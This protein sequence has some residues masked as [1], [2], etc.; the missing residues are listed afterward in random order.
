MVLA[1]P[2]PQVPGALSSSSSSGSRRSPPG[3]HRAG[4][5]GPPE[6]PA[7]Q[8]SAP[9]KQT[10]TGCHCEALRGGLR[11]LPLPALPQVWR[12][13]PPAPPPAARVQPE[14][15]GPKE[16]RDCSRDRPGRDES[17]LVL[18]NTP[19]PDPRRGEP[20]P[21]SGSGSRGEGGARRLGDLALLEDGQTPGPALSVL[22]ADFG[23]TRRTQ[24]RDPIM[25]HH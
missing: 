16:G 23:P 17:Q 5:A 1:L 10:H 15:T 12:A 13:C 11:P 21:G 9:G 25:S 14:T 7:R 20:H 2:V 19:R 6:L 4:C 3:L 18:A 24:P 8:P 22:S